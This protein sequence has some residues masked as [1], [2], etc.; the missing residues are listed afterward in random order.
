MLS[1]IKHN[2][3]LKY[4]LITS[5]T[6]IFIFT[7]LFFWISRQEKQ[8]IL[9]QV[10]K[11]AVILHRQIVLTREWVS[12]HNYILVKKNN[13]ES[14]KSF[15][16]DPEVTDSDNTVYAKIT[17]AMLTRQLSD[18][19]MESN[20]YS[21]N[22]TNINSLNPD[23]KPDDFEADAIIRFISGQADDMSRIEVHDGKKVFR[24]AAPLPIRKSC[25]SCHDTNNEG[26]GSV[27]GCISVFIPFDETQK[28]INRNNFFLFI[29]MTCLT[30][31]V[32]VILFFFTN[33]LIFTPLK[34]IKIFTRRMQ[35]ET[36]EDGDVKIEGDELKEF[37]GIC[38]MIDE[39]LKNRHNE[40][41]QRIQEAT[42]DFYD[43]TINLKQANKELTALNAAKT[44]F[45]SDIS[46]ELRTPLTSIKGAAD[47][48]SRKSSC[49]DPLYLDIIKKNT[50]HLI[51]TIVDF[52]EYSKIGAGRIELDITDESLTA[53]VK[54]VIEAQ[55]ADA[56][57]KNLK[58]ELNAHQDFMIP[59]D[60]YRIYQVVSNLMSN[61]IKFSFKKGKISISILKMKNK[62]YFSIKDDGIGIDANHHH[63]IFNKFHQAP[64]ENAT[65]FHKGSSGIGLAICKGL[66]ET[67]G[68]NIGVESKENAGSRFFFTLPLVRT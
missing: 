66:V 51:R 31:S 24:Y 25:L 36:L 18:Y 40:L 16:S 21:F 46:H 32:V 54:E 27:G 10:K 14:F 37:A 9:E 49:S 28:A 34:E 38:Y 56:V 43:T 8:L 29:T 53:I 63:L 30:G 7:V 26:A 33:K 59:I 22:L 47:I 4:I 2:I 64:R 48:L 50:N 42:R 12:D 44:E 67:H 5:A 62:I 15:L 60:R 39:K 35:A 6:I 68:G 11:Q 57:K 58:I 1:Y 13:G 55:K 19:A 41:E 65:N 23:N 45:F 20:L 61:A 3:S 17:P 52:L